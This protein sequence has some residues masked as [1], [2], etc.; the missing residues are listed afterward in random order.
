MEWIDAAKQRPRRGQRVLVLWPLLKYADDD[1]SQLSDTVTCYVTAV[2]EYMHS[3]SFED[4]PYADCVGYSFD[5]D[6]EYAPQP[7]HWAPLPKLPTGIKPPERD[8]DL[9]EA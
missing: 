9:S 1:C 8:I 2:V 3:D 5:D 4:A 6:S 7:T